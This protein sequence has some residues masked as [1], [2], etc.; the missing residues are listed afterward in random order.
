M[1]RVWSSARRRRVGARAL[2]ALAAILGVTLVPAPAWGQVGG[3]IPAP[4]TQLSPDGRSA[5]DGVRTLSVSQAADLDPAGTTLTVSGSGYDDFKGIYVAFCVI[6]P[7]NQQPTPCGGGVTVEG[8]PGVSHWISSNPPSYGVGLAVPYGPGGSF[9]VTMPVSS[10]ISANLDCQRVRCAVVTRN[11]HSRTTDRS[12]DIFVPVTFAGATT[13]A[14]A[15][16]PAPVAP[17]APSGPAAPTTVASA[18]EVPPPT[19]SD[20]TTTSS[21]EPTTTQP[22]ADD[23]E[24][25]AAESSAGGGGGGSA[26]LL[27][28]AIVLAVVLGG[29]GAYLLVRRRGPAP[30]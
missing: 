28:G 3:T 18:T 19:V 5:T 4:A 15:P 12:Q 11:D 8:N 6:P 23:A 26:G 27:V 13:P 14:L 22:G 24:L 16:S 7:T 2:G 20:S 10:L 17:V 1:T 25:V 29:G 30:A 9:T 21:P